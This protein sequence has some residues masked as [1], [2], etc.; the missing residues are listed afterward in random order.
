MV[1]FG[2]HT[3]LTS[4]LKSQ[5]MLTHFEK[6]DISLEFV[7]KLGKDISL[8]IISTHSQVININNYISLY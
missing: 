6:K 8:H 3:D 1:F 7:K 2:D 5:V 4:N